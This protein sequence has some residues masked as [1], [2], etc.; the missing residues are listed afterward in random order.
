MCIF[1]L[2]Q[3]I[4]CSSKI[5]INLFAIGCRRKL[6]LEMDSNGSLAFKP[7]SEVHAGR[8]SS[9]VWDRFHII[10]NTADN[11]IIQ[12]F[13]KCINCGEFIEYNGS[14]TSNLRNHKCRHMKSIRHEQSNARRQFDRKDIDAI[15]DATVKFVAFDIRPFFAIQGE[16]LLDLLI[17]MAE[18]GS[19]YQNMSRE[20]IRQLIPSRRTVKR[21]T[22]IKANQMKDLIKKRFRE[23]LACPGGLSCTIDM[24][25][26]KHTHTSYLGMTAHLSL[27]ENGKIKRHMYLFNV[28]AIKAERMTGSVI[29]TE[30]KRIFDEFGINEEEIE[31][32]ITFVSDRGGNI[33]SALSKS[34]RLNCYAHLMNN[35]VHA[36][37]E[38]STMRQIVIDSAAL[39]RFVNTSTIRNNETLRK[40][41]KQHCETRWNSVQIMLDSIYSNYDEIYNA[42]SE[43]EKAPTCTAHL[44][45]KITCL[46]KDELNALVNFLSPFTKMTKNIEGDKCATIHKV[47]PIYQKIE[48]Y[49]QPKE[50]DMP[51]IAE[52][53]CE[54]L[55][56]FILNQSDFEPTMTHKVAVFLHPVLK[57]MSFAPVSTAIDV[58][59]FVQ[60]SMNCHDQNNNDS[61]D[62]NGTTQS[63]NDDI[64]DEFLSEIGTQAVATRSNELQRYI[65][66]KIDMVS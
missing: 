33:R 11:E 44:T 1:V 9:T 40:T 14:T 22:E 30:V 47:W 35:I 54:G 3:Q 43:K 17:T 26:E 4:L 13:V 64:F 57:S 19:R 2:N 37:C 36:M 29:Y 45:Q 20:D 23:A 21:H 62:L 32:K 52:M 7:K 42:L 51:I 65:D 50:S 56:Y 27:Q 41:L 63:N 28:N 58:Q 49:L 10:V 48:S 46:K 53:R 39:V 55:R 24:W 25:S 38:V 8:C 60:D 5:K 31:Q 16:G 59:T 12:N 15:R 34:V 66:F 18:V 6:L 61:V